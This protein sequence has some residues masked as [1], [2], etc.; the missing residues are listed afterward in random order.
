MNARSHPTGRRLFIWPAAA[1]LLGALISINPWYQPHL[2]LAFAV[3]AWFLDLALVLVLSAR[4]AT[5]PLGALVAGLFLAVPGYL[6][7]TPLLRA[8]LMC[9]MALPL[10]IAALPFLV[11]NVVDFGAR[12]ACFFTWLGARE[13]R[14]CPRTFH[15]TAVIHL[16][17]ATTVGAVALAAVKSTP[18]HGPFLSLR[19]F[20]GGIMILALAEMITATHDFLTALVG[21]SAPSLMRS[22]ALSRSLSEFW[23]KRWN[24]AASLLLFRTLCFQPLARYGAVTALF[25]AFLA[26]ALA[27]VLLPLMASGRWDISLLCGAF[28]LLQPPFILLESRLHVRRWGPFTARVWTLGILTVTSPLFV[29][30]VLQLLESSWNASD[31][32]LANLLTTLAFVIALNLFVALGSLASLPPKSAPAL[33]A[34]ETLP[35]K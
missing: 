27:H 22:P 34:S 16:L 26:S 4:P 12:V 6:R 21:V 32:L 20:A 11:P 17:I 1:V 24:P 29:E 33:V 25:A 10:A 7:D 35:G 8:L 28:F 19:W 31:P 3:A 18:A 5:A 9:C 14:R 13:V 2:S 23:S 30:P 15:A